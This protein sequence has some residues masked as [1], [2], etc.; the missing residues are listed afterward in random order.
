MPVICAVMVRTLESRQNMNALVLLTGVGLCPT[1]R[2]RR[3]I[4]GVDTLALSFTF[5]A[6]LRHTNSLSYRTGLSRMNLDSIV[7]ALSFEL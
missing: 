2:D 4:N 6:D 7:R 5:G 1:V 3:P